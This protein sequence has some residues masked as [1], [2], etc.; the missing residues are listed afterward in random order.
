MSFRFK[1]F[2][3]I[4]RRDKISLFRFLLEGY[5]GLAILTTI[6]VNKGLVRILVPESR[7]VELWQ[8][9]SAISPELVRHS[10]SKI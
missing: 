3:F 5:D 8:L 1:T 2:F 10:A 9:L 4:V 7:E 6:D